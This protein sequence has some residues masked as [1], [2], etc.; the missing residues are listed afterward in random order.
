MAPPA[1][2]PQVRTF[3]TMSWE[4]GRPCSVVQTPPGP[5]SAWGVVP[6]ASATVYGSGPRATATSPGPSLTGSPPPDGTMK[7]VPRRTDMRQIGARS[8]IRTAQGGSITMR[9]R[10]APR[11][12]GPSR[13]PARASMAASLVL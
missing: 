9:S 6:G 8:S 3:S 2:F 5:M 7:A 11:A 1:A 13:S 10:N 12:R 4:S